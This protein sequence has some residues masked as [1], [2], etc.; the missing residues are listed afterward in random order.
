MIEVCRDRACTMVIEAARVTGFVFRPTNPLPAR[1]VVFWRMRGLVGMDASTTLSPT[2]S[3]HVPAVDASN[4]VDT[5]TNPHCDVNGDGFD[6]VVVGAY[7]ADPSGRTTAGGA[8]VYHGGP[9]GVSPIAASVIEG[10]NMNDQLGRSVAC[11]GDVNGDGYGDVILGA[12]QADPGGRF[13]AG[14]AAIFHGSAA[15]L[16]AAPAL[17]LNGVASN[18]NFGWSVAGAGDVNNDGYADVVVGAPLADPGGRSQAGTV[19]VFGGSPVGIVVASVR[20]IDGLAQNDNFGWSVASA[21][22]VNGDVYSDLVVGAVRA[23]PSAMAEAGMARIFHGSLLGV[24]AIAQ[25]QLPGSA[26]GDLF[27]G[28]VA[29]AGDLNNDGYSDVVVGADSASP[30]GRALAGSASVFHGS[31]VG[32]RAAMVQQMNGVAAGDRMGASV[33]SAGD[34]NG[35]G[36]GDLVLGADQADPGGRANAGAASVYHGSAIGVPS[37]PTLLIEGSLNNDRFGSSVARAGDINGDGYGDVLVGAWLGD[38]RSRQDVGSASIYHGGI[39]GLAGMPAVV[40]EGALA[41]DYFGASVANMDVR[42]NW[43]TN[44]P[45]GWRTMLLRASLNGHV[46]TT[47]RVRLERPL[48]LMPAAL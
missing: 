25:Q 41:N 7:G 19:S 10:V 36:Y 17:V 11:A 22:D 3:F 40:L 44:G 27:G 28:T 23:S 20:T 39:A 33:A 47:A 26:A 30:G 18:D 5:S 43:R 37:V 12:A 35:D 21:G 24:S 16:S 8:S 31:G 46:A 6:D 38:P 4:N 2:W 13:A 15:G 34:L 9:G 45:T 1:S 14:T 48:R 42:T 32:V 29:C